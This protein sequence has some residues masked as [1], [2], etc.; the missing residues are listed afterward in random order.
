MEPLDSQ[1]AP[2]D[3]EPVAPVRPAIW[4][5]VA[6]VLWGVLIAVVTVVTH[7]FSLFLYLTWV[8]GVPDRITAE[9]VINEVRFDRTFS[10]VFHIATLFVAVPL[11]IG[12]VKLKRGSKVNDY[13]GLYW[14]PLKETLRWSIVTL[15]YCL[16]FQTIS[17]IWEPPPSEYMEKAHY[18][19]AFPRWLSWL[20]TII[21]VPI[22]EEICYRGFLLKGLAASRLRWSGATLLTAALWAGVHQ[23]YNWFW[24]LYVFG[25]GVILGLVRAKTN[26][27][28]LTMWLHILVNGLAAA[29]TAFVQLQ[30]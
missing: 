22:Y 27:T 23:Q 17:L 2:D 1:T 15:C 8:R 19:S 26:S 10:W 24:M 14:P 21:A 30:E 5:P 11:I 7:L 29:Q 6:T 18:G 28:L 3:Q 16:L 13:L 9:A 4:G 20:A 25:G 12:I